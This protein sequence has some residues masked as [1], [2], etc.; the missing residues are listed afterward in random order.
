MASNLISTGNA[1]LKAA[2]MAAPTQ[3]RP[4]TPYE[5]FKAKLDTLDGEM[6]ALLGSS[7]AV[8]RFKRVVLNA[9]LENEDLLAADRLSLLTSCTKAAKDGLMPDGVQAHL[10]VY[11]T[12]VGTRDN[13][14]WV[15]K[16]QYMPMVRG[17]LDILWGTGLFAYIDAAAV[18]EKD[19]FVY[20]R[21]LDVKLEHE[22]FLDGERGNVVAAYFVARLKGSESF[23][24]IEV[25]G[26]LDIERIREA[27][28]AAKGPGWTTWYD[29]FAIKSVVKRACK[30]L[31]RIDRLEQ[32]ISA[33]N[34]ALGF[35]FSQSA[36]RSTNTAVLDNNPSPTLGATPAEVE[37]K[38]VAD[39]QGE[40]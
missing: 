6:K 10:N 30:Q 11:R 4:V 14:R 34:E 27:S 18:Y 25:I 17:L 36:H 13:P 31:P 5:A 8:Q 24:K 32:A 2:V 21:G 35:D 15:S 33:D 29:Q 26:K 7:D 9:V 28:K 23:P 20:T 12:N 22:P 40:G 3:E 19:R 39:T 1:A 37:T 38:S 16:V